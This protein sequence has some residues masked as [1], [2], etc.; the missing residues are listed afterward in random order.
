MR[1]QYCHDNDIIVE[2]YSPL[3]STGASHR[4]DSVVV[5]IAK[6]HGVDPANILIS[7]QAAR[8][9]VVLPKSVTPSRIIANFQGA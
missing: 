2:S 3:G 1:L 9:C 8:G 6:A 5:E 7:W 4:E